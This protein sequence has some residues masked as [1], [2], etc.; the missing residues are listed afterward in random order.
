VT[1]LK[2]HA[3]FFLVP[4]VHW[5]VPFGRNKQFIGRHSQLEELFTK[6][7][8]EDLEDNGKGFKRNEQLENHIRLK[9]PNN[10]DNLGRC[11][12]RKADVDWDENFQDI[13]RLRENTRDLSN[14]FAAGAVQLAEMVLLIQQLQE[15]AG[16][17]KRDS[18]QRPSII[19][20]NRGTMTGQKC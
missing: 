1:D 6:L 14:Q 3:N 9:H 17:P 8:P 13:K 12:K 11:L 4:K 20:K 7:D 10:G 16:T 5:L 2:T 19:D 18:E 15:N